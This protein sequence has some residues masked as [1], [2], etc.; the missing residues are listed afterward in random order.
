MILAESLF[1]VQC[2]LHRTLRRWFPPLPEADAKYADP[3]VGFTA[4]IR[5][6]STVLNPDSV[7][8]SLDGTVVKVRNHR[9]R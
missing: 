2:R 3:E 7:K 9:R 8:L 5:N 4:V 1:K 6:G